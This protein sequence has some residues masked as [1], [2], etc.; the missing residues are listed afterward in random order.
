VT[1]VSHIKEWV[2]KLEDEHG[3]KVERVIIDYA[4][5]LAAPD[6][7][8]HSYQAMKYIY[9]SMYAWA[10]KEQLWIDTASATK[11]KKD[12]KGTTGLDEASDSRYKARIVDTMLAL[13][14]SPDGMTI[15]IPKNRAGRSLGTIGPLP[16][17]FECGRLVALNRGDLLDY[18]RRKKMQLARG[19]GVGFVASPTGAPPEEQEEGW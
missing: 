12:K 8:M 9:R 10:H 18:C 14:R 13:D 4:D 7:N 16:H 17:D 11:A 15:S 2:Q 6:P 3:K 5:Y 19:G 1:K